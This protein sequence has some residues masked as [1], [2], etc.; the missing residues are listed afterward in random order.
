MRKTPACRLTL[1]A[2]VCPVSFRVHHN[3]FY[4]K[5]E[6]NQLDTTHCKKCLTSPV[7]VLYSEVHSLYVALSMCQSEGVA[8]IFSMKCQGDT[9]QTG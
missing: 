2:L 3:Q 8:V 6:N 9:A 7:L 5:V 4:E 1:Q